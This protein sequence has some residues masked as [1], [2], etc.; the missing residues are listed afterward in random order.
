[1]RLIPELSIDIDDVATYIHTHEEV[2]LF[3][4][5]TNGLISLITLEDTIANEYVELFFD[6]YK[7]ECYYMSLN[8]KP[9]NGNTQ[10]INNLYLEL[11]AELFSKT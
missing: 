11:T 7:G 4:T 6:I 3:V 5:T 8:D 1:M 2:T 10:Y 9:F